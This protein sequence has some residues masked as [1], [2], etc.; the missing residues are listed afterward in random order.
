MKLIILFL[1][2]NLQLWATNDKLLRNIYKYENNINKIY[3]NSI[4][5]DVNDKFKSFLIKLRKDINKNKKYPT[6]CIKEKKEGYVYISFK[7]LKNGHIKILKL[8]GDNI[9]YKEAKRNIMC[10]SPLNVQGITKK[11]PRKITLKLQYKL[12]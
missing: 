4:Y 5:G 1:F 10:L 2:L 8:Q 12:F 11:L 7:I 9:F 3:Q 6:R